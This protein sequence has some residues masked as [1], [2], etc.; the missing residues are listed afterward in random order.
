MSYQRLENK[1]DVTVDGVWKLVLRIKVLSDEHG[2]VD[3][4]GIDD[5][6]GFRRQNHFFQLCYLVGVE[7]IVFVP[8]LLV[9]RKFSLERG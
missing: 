2:D 3:G 9:L 1:V 8:A 7:G 6:V 4:N 5:V